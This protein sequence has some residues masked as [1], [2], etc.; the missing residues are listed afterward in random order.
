MTRSIE[1]EPNSF[2]LELLGE[3]LAEEPQ[4]DDTLDQ[5]VVVD[6]IPRVMEDRL[7]KLKNVIR[8]I[9]GKFG[10]IVGEYY[11]AD[12]NGQTKG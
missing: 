9:M 8:K 3:L 2:R 5:I 11:P 12:E 7:D 10:T 6:N 1:I 4:L